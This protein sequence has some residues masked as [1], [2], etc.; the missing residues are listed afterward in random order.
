MIPHI[1][2]FVELMIY[3]ESRDHKQQNRTNEMNSL[4]EDSGQRKRY[5]RSKEK[6][7]HYKSNINITRNEWIIKKKAISKFI[8]ELDYNN[9]IQSSYDLTLLSRQDKNDHYAA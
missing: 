9:Q 7:D 4:T 5:I 8:D 6:N 1:R 3:T 2:S